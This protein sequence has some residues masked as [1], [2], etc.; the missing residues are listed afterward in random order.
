MVMA[1]LACLYLTKLRHA[2]VHTM[3]YDIAKLGEESRGG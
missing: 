3:M 2:M 1:M